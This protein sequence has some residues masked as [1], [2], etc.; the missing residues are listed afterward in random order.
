MENYNINHGSQLIHGYCFDVSFKINNQ[1]VNIGFSRISSVDESAE[2][3]VITEG[4]GYMHI[5]PKY[6]SQPKI[7]TFSKG[8]SSAGDFIIDY[9]YV[10]RIIDE[11]IITIGAR[12]GYDEYL[13]KY[14]LKDCVIT[15]CIIQEVDAMKSEAIVENFEISYINKVNVSLQNNSD[16]RKK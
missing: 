16:F 6:V 13:R 7:I 3:E 4:N 5:V 9:L 2:Y 14:L 15:K 11:I 12:G 10:G 1:E 8:I